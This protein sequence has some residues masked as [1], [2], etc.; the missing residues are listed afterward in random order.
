[1]IILEM[2]SQRPERRDNLMIMPCRGL[3]TCCRLL[4][5][6]LLECMRVSVGDPCWVAACFSLG[7]GVKVEGTLWLRCLRGKKTGNTSSCLVREVY[8]LHLATVIHW[9]ACSS[10]IAASTASD[11]CR[12]E[13]LYSCM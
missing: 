2:V 9:Y 8:N 5:F 11:D 7:I 1:V 13:L 6:K 4:V 3:P 10:F 12:R